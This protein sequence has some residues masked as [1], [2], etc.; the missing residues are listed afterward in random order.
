MCMSLS[1]CG[2]KKDL[3]KIITEEGERFA[4]IAVTTWWFYSY[5]SGGVHPNQ[6]VIDYDPWQ[7]FKISDDPS[8][9]R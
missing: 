4:F 9:S 2:H 5:F 7:I 6:T 8:L 1:F 3:K